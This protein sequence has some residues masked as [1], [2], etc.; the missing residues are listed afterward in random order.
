MV[1][2]ERAREKGG[3][4]WRV[5]ER[6]LPPRG[7]RREEGGGGVPGTH[8]ASNTGLS[9]ASLKHGAPWQLAHMTDALQYSGVSSFPPCAVLDAAEKSGLLE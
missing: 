4:G 3:A 1:A 2:R 5:S 9:Y 6:V 7:R 8:V